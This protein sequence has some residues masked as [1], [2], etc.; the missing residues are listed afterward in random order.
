MPSITLGSLELTVSLLTFRIYAMKSKI[1]ATNPD[2]LQNSINQISIKD[3]SAN[4]TRKPNKK[5]TQKLYYR[6]T[7]VRYCKHFYRFRDKKQTQRLVLS[8]IPIFLHNCK[9]IIENEE[10]SDEDVVSFTRG[11]INRISSNSDSDDEESYASEDLEEM[12]EKLAIA[13]EEELTNAGNSLDNIQWNEFANKQ[14]SFI[15]TGKSGLLMDLPSNISPDEVLSLF[16]DEKEKGLAEYDLINMFLKRHPDLSVRKSKDV[17][18]SQC[19]AMNKL[20][21]EYV[22]HKNLSFTFKFTSI[23]TTNR[24][25]DLT[26][27]SLIINVNKDVYY[28]LD[29]Q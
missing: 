4:R 14:Q 10:S 26:I 2:N 6:Y 17:S 27:E 29:Y 21:K 1:A 3:Y 22:E 7:D 20:V 24:G 23:E 15:F 12:L 11:I 13:K 25:Q 9:N 28:L 8:T 5:Q 18:L 16:L 19:Q